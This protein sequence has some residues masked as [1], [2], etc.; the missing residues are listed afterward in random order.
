LFVLAV[1]THIAVSVTELKEL[2]VML[3]WWI[4]VQWLGEGSCWV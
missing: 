4:G 1:A 3:H 2:W